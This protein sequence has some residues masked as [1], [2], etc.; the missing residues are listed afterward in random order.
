MLPTTQTAP[1][2]E[3]SE[4]RKPQ[5][6]PQ[7]TRQLK[8]AVEQVK[9]IAEDAKGALKELAED[10]KGKSGKEMLKNLAFFFGTLLLKN[11]FSKEEEERI[12]ARPFC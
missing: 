3:L 6:R 5:E 2:R 7:E 11:V 8:T 12:K 4:L 1:E 10:M 9:D